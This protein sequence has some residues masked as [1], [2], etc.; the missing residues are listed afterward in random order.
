MSKSH[1]NPHQMGITNG[2]AYL[3]AALIGCHL[4]DPVNQIAGR[5]GAIL[6]ASILIAG[7]SI[8]A[9]CLQNFDDDGTGESDAWKSLVALRLV[10]GIGMGI[11]AVSTPILA[12]E[13]AIGYWRG[14]TPV[15]FC[16]TFAMVLDRVGVLAEAG[17]G[18]RRQRSRRVEPR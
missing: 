1:S 13:T 4:S 5:R 3:A 8:G 12:S 7:T 2:I 10:N 11:K 9:A 17:S 16:F 6:V 14:M 15:S 18:G